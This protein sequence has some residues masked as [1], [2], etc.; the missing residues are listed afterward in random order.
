[1]N[2]KE[3]QFEAIKLYEVYGYQ[4]KKILSDT[5]RKMPSILW[6]KVG[7]VNAKPINSSNVGMA[8]SL[9]QFTLGHK[10]HFAVR[11]KDVHN[12]LGDFSAPYS[13]G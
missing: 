12:R 9:N 8:C 5:Q 3:D 7:D 2:Y 10:Y 13:I 6:K 4:E 11:A 1:M